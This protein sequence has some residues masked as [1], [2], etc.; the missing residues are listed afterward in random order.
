[1]FSI[2]KIE[3]KKDPGYQWWVTLYGLR[4]F[5]LFVFVLFWCMQFNKKIYLKESKDG[6]MGEIRER[7]EKG[8]LM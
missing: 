2:V 8:K 4:K 6:D 7:K 5:F 3:G 1:M